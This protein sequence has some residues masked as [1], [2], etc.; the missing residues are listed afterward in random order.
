MAQARLNGY[1]VNDGGQPCN[2]WFEWGTTVA[3]GK[4]TPVTSGLHAGDSFYYRLTGL[5]DR[6]TYHYRAVAQ[7]SV[8]V[9]FGLDVT[10]VTPD[11]P[12]MITLMQYELGD[13]LVSQR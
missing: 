10:F 3:Y 7:N 1:L 13:F 9:F 12:H 4:S 2:V 8:L 11:N 6:T 5:L